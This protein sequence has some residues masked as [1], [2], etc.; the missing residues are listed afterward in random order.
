MVRP[1]ALRS[2]DPGFKTRS[3]HSLNFVP[4]S[5]WFNF[6]AALVNSQLA[7]LRPVGIYSSCCWMFCSVVIVF[8]WPWKAPMGS[9]QLSMYCR[10]VSN[11][12]S[13][14]INELH[15]FCVTLLSD[16]FKLLAPFFQPIRSETKTNRG[17]HVHIYSRFVPATCSYF[18]SWLVYWIVSVLFDRP[19]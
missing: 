16:W 4:C 5:P 8:H 11:W 13:K 18:E 3:D 2:G 14:V 7:S 9:A 6:S 10:A 1:L 12:V 15:W 19:K 17:S